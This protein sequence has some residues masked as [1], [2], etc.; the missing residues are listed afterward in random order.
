MIKAGKR[1]SIFGTGSSIG[2]STLAVALSKK[3]GLPIVHLDQIYY[4]PNQNSWR[5]KEEYTQLHDAEI[6]KSEWIIEGNYSDTM[7][8][9]FANSDTIIYIDM[10][11]LAS[12]WRYLKRYRAEVKHNVKQIGVLESD[13]VKLN[14]GTIWYLLQPKIFYK[15]R[16]NATKK[17]KKLLTEHKS[18]IIKIGSFKEMN[19]LIEK[20]ELK[21]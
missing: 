11:R 1:I 19:Q 21:N 15:R 13:K 14:W 20:L 6:Q 16:R 9:R 10:S 17:I 7:I 18:K 3:F 8:Q 2:K 12:V 4:I 5:P